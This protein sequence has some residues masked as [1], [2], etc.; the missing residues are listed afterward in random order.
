MKSRAQMSR[1]P[2]SRWLS[3]PA[4]VS[5]PSSRPHRSAWRTGSR[6]AKK[7]QLHSQSGITD[8]PSFELDPTGS[9]GDRRGFPG[10]AR[11]HREP[12]AG[13]DEGTKHSTAPDAKR[14]GGEM[15]PHERARTRP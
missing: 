7:T 4:S 9:R 14:A 3:M 15:P 10:P 13:K 8:S 2:A 5:T 1:V 6:Q 11:G 12:G